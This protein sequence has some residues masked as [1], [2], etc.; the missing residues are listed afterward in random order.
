MESNMEQM[1]LDNPELE[2]LG[3]V[4][5][6]LESLEPLARMRVLAAVRPLLGIGS[7]Q[8]VQPGI[9]IG[10]LNRASPGAKQAQQT[11]AFEF[12]NSKRPN[13]N[14]Q[15]L[16]CIAYFM[17]HREGVPT[18]TT[19]SMK[20]AYTSAMQPD[21]DDMGRTLSDAT[22]RAGYFVPIDKKTKRLSARGASVVEALPDQE[23]V[24]RVLKETAKPARR[25]GRRGKGKRG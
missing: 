4:F 6:A 23:V 22:L 10:A 16:A 2:A 17:E 1:G 12:V 20:K 3:K 21:I 19:S 5:S 13:D 18:F 9:G 11:S 25:S 7:D 24:K 15:R 14:F 8:A